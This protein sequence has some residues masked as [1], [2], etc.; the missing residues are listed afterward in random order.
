MSQSF[1]EISE[2]WLY[3]S[4]NDP[5]PRGTKVLGI[6]DQEQNMTILVIQRL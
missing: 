4:K 1:T 6:E 3:L 2:Q 5:E